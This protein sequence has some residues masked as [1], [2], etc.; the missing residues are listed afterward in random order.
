[1]LAFNL[2][3]ARLTVRFVDSGSDIVIG[4]QSLKVIIDMLKG[5]Y[6]ELWVKVMVPRFRRL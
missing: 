1:M 5:L 2:P 4:I 3:A 6:T